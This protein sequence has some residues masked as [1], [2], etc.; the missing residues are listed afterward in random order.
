M[1]SFEPCR[2][3]RYS[4]D[5]GW[6][7]AW[8]RI[9][10]DLKLRKIA[11]RLCIGYGSVARIW[12]R[13]TSTG[14]VMKQS[15]SKFRAHCHTLDD[16]HEFFI[17]GLVFQSPTIYLHELRH[18]IEQGHKYRSFNSYHLSF[19]EKIRSYKEKNSKGCFT[20][21]RAAFIANMFLYKRNALVW[22]DETGSDKRKFLKKIWLCNERRKSSKALIYFKR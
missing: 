3:K 19:V 10:M 7:V 4:V 21:L 22:F 9:V 12:K 20:I 6:R 15:S 18:S 2:T 16:Y 5:I 1:S 17:L 14:D 8:L 13:F 11:E